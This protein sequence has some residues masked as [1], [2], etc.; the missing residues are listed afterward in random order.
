VGDAL[1]G[2]PLHD[3]LIRLDKLLR[4]ES[5]PR[6]S[7]GV[8]LRKRFALSFS[9]VKKALAMEREERPV[10]NRL[11]GQADKARRA[12]RDRAEIRP[13]RECVPNASWNAFTEEHAQ[14][15]QGERWRGTQR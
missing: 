4:L 13:G 1:A 3:R 5:V 10:E 2:L 12:N 11:E 8:L 15:F 6:H 14:A 7:L 9:G